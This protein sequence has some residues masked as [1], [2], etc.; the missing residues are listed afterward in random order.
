MFAL[1]ELVARAERALGQA[2]DAMYGSHR[3]ADDQ[4]ELGRL[5]CEMVNRLKVYLLAADR[6][7]DDDR[8]VGTANVAIEFWNEEDQRLAT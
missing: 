8:L 5:D 4:H 1:R 2:L 7:K 3:A 6:L